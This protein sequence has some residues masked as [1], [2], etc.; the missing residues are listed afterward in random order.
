[1]SDDADRAALA[2]L[3]FESHQRVVGRPLS[4]SALTGKALVDALW[5][6]PQVLVAHGLGD[7]PLFNYGNAAALALFEMTWAQF[8]ATPSRASAEASNQAARARVMADVAS[9]GYTTGYRGLR[10]SRTGQR[11]WIEDTTIWNVLDADGRY[12]GQAA[13]FAHWTPVAG[14]TRGQ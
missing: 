10:V 4:N 13:T 3:L 5:R 11:F 6:M 9:R 7:D 8:I 14:P 1:M 2:L 12:C